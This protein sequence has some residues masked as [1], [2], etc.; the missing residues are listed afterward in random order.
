MY[1]IVLHHQDSERKKEATWESVMDGKVRI[2][3]EYF[4]VLR[5]IFPLMV[6]GGGGGGRHCIFYQNKRQYS[7]V[8]VVVCLKCMYI[9]M[10]DA[11]TI[12][13][14]FNDHHES[15]S[16]KKILISSLKHYIRLLLTDMK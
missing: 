1:E 14:I 6:W 9:S 8:T 16:M 5:Q 3:L 4:V 2:R 13:N 11:I 15:E 10:T 7:N 12:Y